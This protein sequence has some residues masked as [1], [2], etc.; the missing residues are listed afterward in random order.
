MQVLAV[1]AGLK[2]VVW[3]VGEKVESAPDHIGRG[4]PELQQFWQAGKLTAVEIPVAEG[5]EYSPELFEV[6]N[7]VVQRKSGGAQ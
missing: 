7:N 6:V 4:Y 5:E 1:H 3:L 2:I